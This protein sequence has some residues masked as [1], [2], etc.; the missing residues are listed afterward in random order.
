[1]FGGL[2]STRMSE[3]CLTKNCQNERS[4]GLFVGDF[5]KPCHDFIT[6]GHGANNQ[7]VKNA[8]N[9]LDR[10]FVEALV[11]AKISLES[12]VTSLKDCMRLLPPGQE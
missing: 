6:S 3:N 2:L 12:V 1:M 10:R 5:C 4:Q 8:A 9:L 7:V 11:S